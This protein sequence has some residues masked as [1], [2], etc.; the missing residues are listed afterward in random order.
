MKEEGISVVK[1]QQRS[2]GVMKMFIGA[3][4]KKSGKEEFQ[5]G[6]VGNRISQWVK[7]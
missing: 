3:S 4:N 6:G 7:M 2:H 5:E 1:M